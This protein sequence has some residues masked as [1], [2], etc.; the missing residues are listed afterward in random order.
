MCFASGLVAETALMNRLVP[1]DHV[2]RGNDVHGGTHRLFRRVFERYGIDFSFVDTTDVANV[3]AAIGE[4]TR[5][6]YL[7]TRSTMPHA[8]IPRRTGA[9]PASR[10]AWCGSR[11]V[12]STP[13]T[14]SRTSIGR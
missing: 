8:S 14:W 13:T 3:E 2:V 6:V 9:P 1:G 4:R 5:Y 11:S 12:P 10:T 7:E